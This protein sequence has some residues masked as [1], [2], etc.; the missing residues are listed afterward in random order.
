MQSTSSNTA[1][2]PAN[3]LLKRLFVAQESGL[4]LVIVLL[5]T[6]LT[7]FSGKKDQRDFIPIDAG[8]QV[9]ETSGSI[10]ATVKGGKQTFATSDGWE[11]RGGSENQ[12]VQRTRQVNKFLNLENLMQILLFA[13]FIAIMAVG[14]TAV[15]IMSGIDLSIGSTYALAALIAA[16]ALRYPWATEGF[17]AAK[18]RESTSLWYVFAIAGVGALVAR[19][20]LTKLAH[21][22]SAT[23]PNTRSLSASAVPTALLWAGVGMLVAVAWQLIAA[24]HDTG[25]QV[26]GGLLA[27]SAMGAFGSLGLGLV[28]CLIIGAF[29]GWLNGNM[30]VGLRVHPFIITL[31]TMAAFRGITALPTQAQSVGNFPD[32]F[33]NVIKW[34][35][36]NG[37]TPVPILIMIVTCLAGVVVLSRTVIGRQIYAIGGN[38]TA[39]TYAG[40]PVGKVKK[41][42][43]TMMGALAG[44]SAFA[45]LGYFGGAAPNAGE[46]YELKAIAAAVIGGASLS[47]GRGSALGAVLGAI[48]V[49]LIDNAMVI[50]EIDQ[51]YNKVV[52]GGAIIIAVVLDQLKTRLVPVGK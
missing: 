7:I 3:T 14:I 36:G 21:A 34:D 31:G 24:M 30:V 4:V 33:Q 43:Y 5:M 48:L 38:E 45:Y 9:A 32:S 2:Q 12:S 20:V 39:A 41:I 18:I 37:I 44:L 50:L 49:Q 29:C 28:V 47:G 6:I 46:G 19:A 8:T 13:S 1:S 26:E 40:I 15:I 35:A 27:K 25:R 11:L 42:V 17:P 16:I 51:S 23:S 22:K 10:T 52:L